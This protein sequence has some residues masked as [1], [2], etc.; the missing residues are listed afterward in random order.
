MILGSVSI[1]AQNSMKKAKNYID[2]D[3]A[4]SPNSIRLFGKTPDTK[5]FYTYVGYGRKLKV[6][7]NRVRINITHGI[8]PFNNYDYPQRDKGN[9]KDIISGFGVSPLGYQL[10]IP[11]KVFHLFMGLKTGIIY[12][13]KTFPT[14]KGRKLNYTFDV[15]FGIK[16]AIHKNTFLSL[17]Y[18]FHHISN[19][20]T[21]TQ[22][23]GID[24]NFLFLSIKQFTNVD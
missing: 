16:K 11:H 5:S 1:S 7:N 12:M 2:I 20:Q 21:G 23:P 10:L 19:A 9:K 22:N 17:G 24:S 13:S 8:I 18:R 4:Y 3:I 15:S 14:Y 6:I